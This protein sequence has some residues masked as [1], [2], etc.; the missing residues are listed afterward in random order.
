M[1]EIT[2]PSSAQARIQEGIAEL[3]LEAERRIQ[4]GIPKVEKFVL[5][6]IGAKGVEQAVVLGAG[7]AKFG[8]LRG[9]AVGMTLIEGIRSP[10]HGKRP[11]APLPGVI[12][13]PELPPAPPE[14]SVTEQWRADP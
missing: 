6:K 5:N 12:P 9:V 7:I 3:I 2:A 13:L 11:E 14:V 4:E 8:P 1:P 10:G